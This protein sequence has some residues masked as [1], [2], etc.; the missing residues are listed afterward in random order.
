MRSNNIFVTETTH[1]IHEAY[2]MLR[3]YRWRKDGKIPQCPMLVFMVNNAKGFYTGGMVD[4]FKGIISTYAWCKQKGVEFRIRYIY[5]FELADYLEPN[6]YDWRLREGEY[7]TCIW[8]STLMR[9]R[10]EYGGR[11]IR[12][13]IKKEQIHFY[14]NRDFLQNINE[15]G[16]TDYTWGELFRELFRPG[17]P[18]AEAVKKKKDE[19]GAPYISAVFRFQNLLGD[20]QEYKF[21]ALENDKEREE[22]ITKCLNGLTELRKKYPDMP[23]LVTSD[24]STFINRASEVQ[25][26]HIIE[27]ERVHI[28]CMSGAAYDTYLKSFVDFYMLAGSQRI[29]SLG[30]S[31]MYPTQFPMYAAKVND[32]AFERILLE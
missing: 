3:H 30:T 23:I 7:T 26:V 18:L 31:D 8:N 1:A 25:G 20:F 21:Q 19:I 11:L 2:Y 9:A 13:K 15:A 22:L 29:F 12:R 14:G 4:R 16:G 17:K 32:I 6:Q 5:P 10:G 27:G 28:G 24:S